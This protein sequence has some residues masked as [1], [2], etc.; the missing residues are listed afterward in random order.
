MSAHMTHFIHH[1]STYMHSGLGFNYLY[2]QFNLGDIGDELIHHRYQQK[3]EP[4]S[5]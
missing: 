1:R 3:V 4:T 5:P 2:L